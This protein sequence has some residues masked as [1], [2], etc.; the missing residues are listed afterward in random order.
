MSK[1]DII[2]NAVFLGILTLS[3]LMSIHMINNDIEPGTDPYWP[4]TFEPYPEP[5]WED[6]D[7]WH[8]IW[9]NKIDTNSNGEADDIENRPKPRYPDCGMGGEY[10]YEEEIFHFDYHGKEG[11]SEYGEYEYNKW[12]EIQ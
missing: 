4:E 5:D 6:S 1:E 12:M 3:I 10:D 2:M 9:Y 11:K 7:E 8:E